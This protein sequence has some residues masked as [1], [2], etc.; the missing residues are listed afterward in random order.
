M[1]LI[2]LSR[3]AGACKDQLAIVTREWPNG[4]PVTQASMDR[5]VA[6]KLDIDWA[7]KTLLTATAL[8][9]Y[10]RVMAPAMVEYK[11]VMAPAMVE[12]ERVTDTAMVEYERVR[13][14]ALAEY[15]RVKATARAKYE[16][17][18]DTYQRAKVTIL[19]QL[20]LT[21]PSAVR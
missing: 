5:A 12:Y 13:A 6:L 20:L 18:T 21:T 9:E 15:E 16:R 7:A 14:T 19:L 2:P 4:I 8:V 11:R 1:N 17:V 3:L 10:E